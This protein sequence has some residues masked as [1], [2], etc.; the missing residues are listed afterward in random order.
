MF[1]TIQ[2]P[3]HICFIHNTPISNTGWWVSKLFPYLLNLFVIGL[4]L[5]SYRDLSNASLRMNWITQASKSV[6]NWAQLT[7]RCLYY[8]VTEGIYCVRSPCVPRAIEIFRDT[9]HDSNTTRYLSRNGRTRAPRMCLN[10]PHA[11]V[12][13]DPRS[14]SNTSWEVNAW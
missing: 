14:A 4:F 10:S 5:E 3:T 11:E 6:W 2:N 9:W 12:K 8:N 13:N 1:V 7:C